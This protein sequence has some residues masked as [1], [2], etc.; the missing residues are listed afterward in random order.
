MIFRKRRPKDIEADVVVYLNS[1]ELDCIR[2]TV[3]V[4]MVNGDSESFEVESTC[5]LDCL[6]AT[7]TEDE[8]IHTQ[9]LCIPMCNVAKITYKPT[10]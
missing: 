8:Y 2:Y 5:V 10:E 3:T 6:L 4:V 1:K 9:G 7:W